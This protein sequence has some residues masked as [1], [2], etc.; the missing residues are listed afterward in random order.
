MYNSKYDRNRWKRDSNKDENKIFQVP[1][2]L[3]VIIYN[4]RSCE[5]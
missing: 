5:I 1:T 3:D 2:K 4:L